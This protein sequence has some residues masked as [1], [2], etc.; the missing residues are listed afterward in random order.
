MEAKT[1]ADFEQT[2]HLK[3]LTAQLKLNST[4]LHTHRGFCT[5]LWAGHHPPFP[6]PNITS[7]LQTNY[8]QSLREDAWEWQG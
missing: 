3:T 4:S 2:K 8:D 1:L 7:F 6:P 5:V